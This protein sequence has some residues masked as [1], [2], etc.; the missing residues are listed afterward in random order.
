VHIDKTRDWRAFASFW[1]LFIYTF[2]RIIFET[3]RNKSIST[4]V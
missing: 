3:F 2:G 4:Y 1:L